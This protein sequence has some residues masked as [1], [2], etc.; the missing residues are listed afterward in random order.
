[1]SLYQL[2]GVAMLAVL[3]V[4]YLVMNPTPRDTVALLVMRYTAM[5]PVALYV[6]VAGALIP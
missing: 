2:I 4:Y 6:L 3:I 1:M 5:K